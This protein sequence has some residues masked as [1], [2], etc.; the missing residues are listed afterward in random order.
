MGKACSDYRSK[1][2]VKELNVEPTTLLELETSA[3]AVAIKPNQTESKCLEL[4][5]NAKATDRKPPIKNNS[6]MAFPQFCNKRLQR[7]VA[8]SLEVWV[9]PSMRMVFKVVM[10]KAILTLQKSPE[11]T[12]AR[13]RHTG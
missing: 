5:D 7:A 12:L 6:I 9:W 13:G 3:Y 1:L 10:R 8:N 11:M 2:I 4:F